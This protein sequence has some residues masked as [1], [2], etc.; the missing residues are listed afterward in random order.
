MDGLAEVISY[1]KDRYA[2]T[3]AERA[4]KA[5]Q[6]NATGANPFSSITS[7]HQLDIGQHLNKITETLNKLDFK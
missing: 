7:K 5:A 4:K 1:C 3:P 2:V 6:A